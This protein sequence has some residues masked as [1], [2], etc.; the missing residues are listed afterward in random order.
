MVYF[1]KVPYTQPAN[2]NHSVV[3]GQPISVAQP[4]YGQPIHV[5]Q[6][7]H[8]QPASYDQSI[9]YGQPPNQKQPVYGSAVQCNQTFVL[10]TDCSKDG[11]RKTIHLYTTPTR[12]QKHLVNTPIDLFAHW[13]IC[14]Q[15][16]CYELVKNRDG[17]PRYQVKSTDQ[18][19]WLALKQREGRRCDNRIAGATYLSREKI[20]YIADQIWKDCLQCTY[21]YDEKNCQVFIRLLVALIADADTRVR[22]PQFFDQWAKAFGLSRDVSFMTVATGGA[23]LLASLIVAPMDPSGTAA[24][25]AAVTIITTFGSCVYLFNERL[26]KEKTIEKAQQELWLRLKREGVI[27]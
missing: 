25:T 5:K 24:A 3:Y 22:L 19:E 16:R 4:S 10:A 21:I 1:R 26:K 20:E 18:Q 13:A 9:V 14:I 27:L 23:C 11:Y 2:Y 12:T 6:P 17:G 7:E 15:D 8:N